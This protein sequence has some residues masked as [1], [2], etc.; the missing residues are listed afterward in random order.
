MH[1]PAGWAIAILRRSLRAERSCRQRCPAR[2]RRA[3]NGRS[4]R[5]GRLSGEDCAR[6][7]RRRG[8]VKRG[9]R[10]DDSHRRSDL[11]A[12]RSGVVSN[13]VTQ[14]AQHGPRR[15]IRSV[16]LTG[17]DGRDA[18]ANAPA[19]AFDHEHIAVEPDA[20]GKLCQQRNNRSEDAAAGK[21]GMDV[22]GEWT[23]VYEHSDRGFRWE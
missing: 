3:G 20:I 21:I 14:R 2:Q 22:G 18:H 1:P 17:K 16:E 12:A 11:Q 23:A 5:D 7:D 13:R 8:G 4:R 19:A 6:S 9:R 15:N 10:S